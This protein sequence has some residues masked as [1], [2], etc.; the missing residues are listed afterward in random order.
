MTLAEVKGEATVGGT[1]KAVHITTITDSITAMAAS[2]VA[3]ALTSTFTSATGSLQT[4]ITA[5]NSLTSG[6]SATSHN[7]SVS[8]LIVG[9]RTFNSSADALTSSIS[10]AGNLYSTT[11]GYVMVTV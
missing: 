1:V 6:F 4:Q 5:I 7:H 2:A 10:A 9:L 3:Y 11:A 8:S